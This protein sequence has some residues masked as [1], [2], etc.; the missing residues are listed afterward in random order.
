MTLART[1]TPTYN[2][3]S[4]ASW[5]WV[6]CSQDARGRRAARLGFFMQAKDVFTNPVSGSGG[7]HFLQTY[8]CVPVRCISPTLPAVAVLTLALGSGPNAVI[9][10]LVS[11]FLLRL[12][13]IRHPEQVWAIPSRQ[14]KRPLSYPDYKD[15]RDRIRSSPAWSFTTRSPE[16]EQQHRKQRVRGYLVS[17]NYFDVLG[18]RP[19]FWD[20]PSYLKTAMLPTHIC[21][22]GVKLWRLVAQSR[23]GGDLGC[24]MLHQEVE[25]GPHSLFT[26]VGVAPPNFTGTRETV[27][28]PNFGYRA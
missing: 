2:L 27:H 15:L 21:R 7:S 16:P 25:A 14:T 22:R 1:L 6:W 12:L 4:N 26:V 23:F 3:S 28:A 5:D 10:S 11:T 24:R 19:V 17:E 13:P 8:A 18:V 20:V 9:F